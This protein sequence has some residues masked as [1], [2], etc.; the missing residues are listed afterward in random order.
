MN[1]AALSQ[2]PTT[3]L[4]TVEVCDLCGGRTFTERRV[5][6]DPVFK[7]PERWRL[8]RCEGCALHFI[9]PRPSRDAI[10]RFY[11][12]DYSA[13]TAKPALPSWWHGRVS[14]P[15]APPPNLWSRSWQHVRQS[16]SWYQFPRW[17]GDGRVLDIGCGSG[18]RYLDIL[19]ALGWQT[20]GMDPSPAAV[21]AARAKGH[22]VV[23]GVAE[24]QGF[25]DESMDVVTLWHALEHTHSPTQAL[26]AAHR[27]L[28]RDGLLSLGVPNW[29]SLHAK[30]FGEHWQSAEPPR[31]LYQFTKRTLR[32]Y[33]EQAGF[34]IVRMT[35]RTGATSWPRAMRLASNA[36]F[37]TNWQRERFVTV[38][39]PYV[40]FLAMFRFFGVGAELRVLAE[41]A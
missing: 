28:R 36:W 7:G 3:D 31:H 1:A 15:D 11:P 39:D 22:E 41:R 23:E 13:H 24:Q 10:G 26:A 14:S 6:K 34:R 29:N 5:W 17:R 35:T 12:S 4:E 21:A 2:Q 16:I 37:A 25:P 40:A 38:F 18:G 8:V 30:V 20:F 9:N 19:K 27:V 32:R 33:L